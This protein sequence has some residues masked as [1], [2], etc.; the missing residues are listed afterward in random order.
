MSNSNDLLRVE[1]IK[2]QCSKED[3]F[4]DVSS[5]LQAPVLKK[6]AAANGNP[7]AKTSD[8]GEEQSLQC[9][10]KNENSQRDRF[11]FV[12]VHRSADA[13][14]QKFLNHSDGARYFKTKQVAKPDQQD[15]K[16]PRRGKRSSNLS[17]TRLSFNSDLGVVDGVNSTIALSMQNDEH[18]QSPFYPE[19]FENGNGCY[20]AGSASASSLSS[21]YLPK[22]SS[23]TFSSK[24]AVSVRLSRR[25]KSK[26]SSLQASH[27]DTKAVLGNRRPTE[28]L[29]KL[30]LRKNCRR[31]KL[32]PPAEGLSK[33]FPQTMTRISRQRRSTNPVTTR[34][35]KDL[36]EILQHPRWKNKAHS[37]TQA[38]N[39]R[40]LPRK[41]RA[42]FNTAELLSELRLRRKSKYRKSRMSHFATANP[43]DRFRRA[44]SFVRL[45]LRCLE[46]YRRV[47]VVSHVS[48][49]SFAMLSGDMV[50]ARTYRHG[51]TFDP[52]DYRTANEG[53]LNAKL[54]TILTTVPYQ[55]TENEIGY[56]LKRLRAEVEEFA[57]FPLRMQ[58][59]LVKEAWLDEF[60][61]KRVIIRQGHKAE[62]F[63]FIVSG[64][65]LV[66][67][68]RINANGEGYVETVSILK[69]GKSF[70]ELA[71]MRHEQRTNNVVSQTHLAL[72]TVG[73]KEFV[74]IFMHR[75]DGGEPEFITFLRKLPEFN[76]FPLYKVPHNKPEVCAFT[77]FRVGVVIC[78]DS[79]KSD[80][81][82]IVKSGVCRVVKC[83]AAAKPNLPGIRQGPKGKSYQRNSLT[84]LST[85]AGPS[86]SALRA[87]RMTS[88]SSAES[89]L[90]G[91]LM[92]CPNRRLSSFNTRS[93]LSSNVFSQSAMTLK[94]LRRFLEKGGE[95]QLK[96]S[97]LEHKKKILEI[98]KRW[99]EEHPI[100]RETFALLMTGR[101]IEEEVE[102]DEESVSEN[103]EEEDEEEILELRDRIDSYVF[104]RDSEQGESRRNSMQSNFR[105]HIL[106]RN[107]NSLADAWVTKQRKKLSTTSASLPT[108]NE[109]VLPLSS[110]SSRSFNTSRPN[111]QHKHVYIH[112]QTLREKD[113]FGLLPLLFDESEGATSMSLVSEGA[114]C[115]LMNKEFFLK[116]FD[117]ELRE[118]LIRR[119]RPYP[120]EDKLQSD[121]QDQINWNAYKLMT[122][123][124]C[125]TQRNDAKRLAASKSMTSL[126][127]Q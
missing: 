62:T 54:R 112:V 9:K 27:E 1:K 24:G 60:E 80:A 70:G 7:V 20:D 117:D 99:H 71:I 48:Q 100:S 114:E 40:L 6:I 23:S 65:A 8:F 34:E 122:V 87:A 26:N 59:D 18:F 3:N 83:L 77:Y 119:V 12:H 37:Q 25:R 33:N 42:S 64:T 104:R 58:E 22:S 53:A 98:Y 94:D 10:T 108:L 84:N 31:E 111:S 88:Q 113:V 49:M 97:H 68:N 106:R 32:P 115:I 28:D 45:L 124:N 30:K 76:G 90:A 93:K 75:M 85:S 116:N 52:N 19:V 79:L 13:E 101:E 105:A 51:L 4:A 125:L 120:S 16:E 69:R 103:E 102:N 109:N 95:E 82:I 38:V 21:V 46:N 56:A 11:K 47:S 66:T 14:P 91:P 96:R 5:T 41:F 36:N 29:F 61:P 123:R 44:V 74:D 73:R 2:N 35:S 86:T 39:S 121:M 110:K 78:A 55:R 17:L 89:L 107:R 63:Y 118:K 50:A 127:C 43:L 92:P 67:K 15:P 57:E 72:L 81:I 126:M